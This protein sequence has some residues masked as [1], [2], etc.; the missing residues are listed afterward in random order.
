MPPGLKEK[1]ANPRPIGDPATKAMKKR[2]AD[3]VDDPA[4]FRTADARRASAHMRQLLEV[5][6]ARAHKPRAFTMFIDRLPPVTA[7]AAEQAAEAIEARFYK[8]LPPI[9]GGGDK[10]T[11]CI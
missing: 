4:V 8:C 10:P 1:N 7:K 6:I 5:A 9:S 11:L 3:I 2:L